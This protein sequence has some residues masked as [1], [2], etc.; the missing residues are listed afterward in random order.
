[1]T[2]INDIL[3]KK[4]TWQNAE[5][6]E[7]RRLRR[8]AVLKEGSPEQRKAYADMMRAVHYHRLVSWKTCACDICSLY[9]R[10][11]WPAW[12]RWVYRIWIKMLPIV[13]ILFIC[14]NSYAY[15]ALYDSPAYIT[16]NVILSIIGEAEGESQEAREA[17]AC[18]IHYRGSLQGVYGL[19]APRVRY[20]KYSRASYLDAVMAFKA[21]QDEEYCEG[22]VN[23]AQ[24][25]G[26]TIL[27]Q[28]WIR[29]MQLQGYVRTTT[30]GNQAFFRKD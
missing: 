22:L 14:N 27:D 4:R 7:K 11:I 28:E 30:I 25:W 8:P 19:H 17:I 10:K 3:A 29:T 15:T 18:A 9:K 2:D 13:L 6:N 24:Y 21:A 20:H 16:K 12:Y 26:S 1:M 23:G 5:A